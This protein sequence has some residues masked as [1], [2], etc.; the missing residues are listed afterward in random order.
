[1]EI[2]NIIE[3]IAMSFVVGIIIYGILNGLSG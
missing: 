2:S 1:M 3:F